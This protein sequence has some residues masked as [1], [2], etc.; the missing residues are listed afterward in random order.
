MKSTGRRDFIK[1]SLAIAG[2]VCYQQM[3]PFNE[4]SELFSGKRIRVSGHLW[5]YA[6]RF[7]PTHDCTPILETIFSDF[8]YAGIMGVELMDV[9]LKNADAEEN[10]N[11][12]SQTYGVAVT[13]T[14]FEAPMWQKGQHEKIVSDFKPVA[15]KLKNIG[16][17]NV[18]FSVGYKPEKKS[19]SELD[20]Q[21]AVLQELLEICDGLG[22]QPNLHNHTYEVAD[23]LYELEGTLTRV[24]NLTLGPDVA[25][26]FRAGIDPVDFI[27]R[28]GDRICYLHLRDHKADRTWTEAMGDGVIDFPGIAK[29][30]KEVGFSGDAAIEL[31]FEGIPQRPLREN[32]KLSRD[33]VRRVFNW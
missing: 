26:L 9:L 31:S 27:H 22:L 28:F 29:A 4:F 7:P 8:R 16:G 5:Q 15:R 18:G 19:T 12:L 14:S 13:G 23:N 17:K 20:A 2:L 24:E 30:L 33:Y 10:F 6:S 32:W 3:L 25:H 21:A 1:G 11:K